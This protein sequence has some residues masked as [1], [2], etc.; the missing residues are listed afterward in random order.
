MVYIKTLT[1]S[2]KL[3]LHVLLMQQGRKLQLDYKFV[4]HTLR[5]CGVWPIFISSKNFVHIFPSSNKLYVDFQEEVL[6]CITVTVH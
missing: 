6:S 4:K 5:N 1:T 3:I 2:T